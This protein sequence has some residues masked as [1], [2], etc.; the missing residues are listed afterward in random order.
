MP[1]AVGAPDSIWRR[2]V[3][4]SAPLGGRPASQRGQEFLLADISFR[5]GLADGERAGQLS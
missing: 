2:S 5:G 3:R 1:P 4:R